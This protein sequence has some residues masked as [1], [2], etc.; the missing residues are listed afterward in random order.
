MQGFLKAVRQQQQPN[1][2]P[3]TRCEDACQAQ[4]FWAFNIDLT[5][6]SN[7]NWEEHGSLTVVTRTWSL[8][9]RSHATGFFDFI[10]CL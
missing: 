3:K 5:L 10:R 9:Y 8:K 1:N 6:G 4:A 2:L 7:R